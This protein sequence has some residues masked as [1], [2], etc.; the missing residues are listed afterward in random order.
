[1][2]DVA[3]IVVGL[4]NQPANFA[5][6]YL[7]A[8]IGML[9]ELFGAVFVAVVTGAI[10]LLIF[11][12]TSNQSAVRRVR[13]RMRAEFLALS[14]FRDSVV[15]CLGCQY[16][17]VL[18]AL[19]LTMLALVPMA[20]MAIPVTLLLSQLGLWWQARP[21]KPGQEV[22]VTVA[23]SG[24]SR[25]SIPEV[26]LES[27]PN[28]EVSLGPVVVRSRR[29][30]SWNIRPLQPGMHVLQFDVNGKKLEKQLAVGDHL[31]RVSQ[32]RSERDWYVQM[33]HPAEGV[34]KS[35]SPVK[36]IEIQ[37]PSSDSWVTGKDSWILFWFLTSTAAAL[38]L[39][40]IFKVN[41]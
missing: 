29:F 19:H 36:T 10:L 39:R 22:V 17:I 8:P 14:L 6:R 5:G 15:V 35:D 21:V 16:R 2:K 40:P 4:L 38:C 13:S 30:V 23:F 20:I 18:G 41:L 31:L 32:M 33:L 7:L 26:T 37:Y 1:M 34:I 11:K 27:D 3:A 9:P 24:N 28:L 12:Y 25:D